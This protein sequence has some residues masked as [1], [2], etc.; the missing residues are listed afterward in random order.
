MQFLQRLL[1]GG[2]GHPGQFFDADF[3]RLQQIGNQFV[4]A[5]LGVLA[6]VLFDVKFTESI[7]EDPKASAP[8]GCLDGP[9]PTRLLFRHACE[10]VLVE[11]K[12]GINEVFREGRCVGVKNAE[13][14]VLLPRLQVGGLDDRAE[15]LKETGRS[16][17][18]VLKIC[19]PRSR[20]KTL[21]G[22]DSG[23]RGQVA[24]GVFVV[25]E[26]G[27]AEFDARPLKESQFRFQL[28]DVGC[29][30]FAVRKLSELKQADDVGPQGFACFD[31][32]LAVDKVVVAVG[33]TGAALVDR[34]EVLF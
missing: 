2:V 19:S 31:V 6:E 28:D 16:D 12:G 23:E 32:L 4:H 25:A 13:P 24:D 9:L 29:R 7:A 14:N 1:F 26:V 17:V 8:R 15:R 22:D 18:E 10:F 5:A 33:Q 27:V 20:E 3:I 30:L 11:L 21:P 34:R